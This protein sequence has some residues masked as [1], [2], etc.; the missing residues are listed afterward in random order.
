MFNEE[1]ALTCRPSRAEISRGTPPFAA[2][3]CWRVSSG[4]WQRTAVGRLA[5]MAA[6]R[7]VVGMFP[8]IMLPVRT[9]DYK[10]GYSNSF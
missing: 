5:S 1:S 10:W 2:W 3:P 9:R 6:W 8:L 7:L 4:C